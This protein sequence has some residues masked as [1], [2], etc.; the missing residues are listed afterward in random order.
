MMHQCCYEDRPEERVAAESEWA[1]NC[2]LQG[3]SST[4]HYHSAIIDRLFNG[5]YI[6]PY[7]SGGKVEEQTVINT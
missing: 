5:S 4:K 2:R 6:K 1:I 3:A 7:L